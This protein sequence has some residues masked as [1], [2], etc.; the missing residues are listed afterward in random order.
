M[1]KPLSTFPPAA[2][3]VQ[4]LL[5]LSAVGFFGYN[6]RE[7]RPPNNHFIFAVNIRRYAANIHYW[8]CN[9]GLDFQ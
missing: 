8:A 7:R 4:Q 2:A 6:A 9:H 5:A 3:T 1:A